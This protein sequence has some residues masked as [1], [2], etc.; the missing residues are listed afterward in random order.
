MG[1]ILLLLQSPICATI[2]NTG[3]AGS[4][5]VAELHTFLTLHVTCY[6]MSAPGVRGELRMYNALVALRACIYQCCLLMHVAEDAPDQRPVYPLVGAE[7]YGRKFPP[8]AYRA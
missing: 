5:P 6:P 3:A 1:L 2:A 7:F 8:I 4:N